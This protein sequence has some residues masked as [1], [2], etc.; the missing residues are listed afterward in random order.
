MPVKNMH[1]APKNLCSNSGFTTGCRILEKTVMFYFV[2]VVVAVYTCILIT[3]LN[4][5]G[6][7]SPIKRHRLT[8]WVKKQNLPICC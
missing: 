2:V 5:S 4:I 8:E 1:V 6:F 3:T 7:N